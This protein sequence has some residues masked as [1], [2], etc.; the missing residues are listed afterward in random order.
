MNPFE[1]LR[2]QGDQAPLFYAIT[3]GAGAGL[4]KAAWEVPGVS[5][6]LV[7]TAMPY[8]MEETDRILGFTPDLSPRGKPEYVCAN[9]AIDL[10]MTAYMRA[11]RPGR[12]AVG[13]GMTCSVASK[14]AHRH[15]DHRVVAAIFSEEGCWTLSV[16]IV[17]GEGAEQR[18]TDGD[19][20]DQIAVAFLR[21]Y[22][23]AR[24]GRA[25]DL[26]GSDAS[27]PYWSEIKEAGEAARSRL[28]ARPLF[29]A[30]GTRWSPSV[31][32]ASETLF[33]PGAY[34]PPHDG[35]FKGGKKSSETLATKR[36]QF[37]N[38]VFSTTV[39][40]P[41]KDAISVAECLQRAKLMKGHDFLLTE[42]DP[43]Y[44]H[45][46]RNFP[47]AYFVMGADAM[48]RMLDEKWGEPVR[49]MLDEFWSLGS[50][51][52]VPG[53]LVG[54]TFKTC[55]TVMGENMGVVLG[56]SLLFEP[57]DFRL[58]LSSTE[59]RAKANGASGASG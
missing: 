23:L 36:R 11:W 19:L 15:G 12:K 37:R 21:W 47:G 8:A 39:N 25:S 49:P 7:G 26:E 51:F 20:S 24:E 33:Y 27:S 5:S 54:D 44:I 50:C 1:Y 59:L 38:L 56:R 43:L 45:K 40:P 41:H 2:D 14:V 52:L 58:D 31:I 28:F 17:K 16:V 18:K 34:H 35:H 55:G 29:K 30:D 53:R 57:V 6:F 46:A 42:D 4:Q 22:L 9:T 32:V 10:A 3:T 48:A 13:L